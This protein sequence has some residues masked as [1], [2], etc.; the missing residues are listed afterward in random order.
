MIQIEQAYF[1]ERNNQ[2][3]LLCSSLNN[4]ELHRQLIPLTDRPA[5]LN[6]VKPY[7]SGY[8]FKEY[9]VFV[10]T[11]PDFSAQR[12]GLVFSHSLILNKKDI[13]FINNLS[14]IFDLFIS[15]PLKETQTIESLF[16]EIGYFSKP[17]DS[18]QPKALSTVIKLMLDSDK[19]VVW[20]GYEY[21]RSI[22]EHLWLK[23]LPSM[24]SNFKFRLSDNPNDIIDRNYSIVYIPDQNLSKWTN[25]NVVSSN[26]DTPLT[27]PAELFLQ[28]K[29]DVDFNYFIEKF[30]IELKFPYELNRI[31]DCYILYKESQFKKDSLLYNRLVRKIGAI[32][33]SP[34]SVIDLKQEVLQSFTKA[35]L[36]SDCDTIAS[37]RSINFTPYQNGVDDVIIVLAKWCKINFVRKTTQSIKDLADLILIFFHQE[38]P[39][40]WQTTIE[41]GLISQF[42]ELTK[43]NVSLLFDI[44]FEK[45][46][47]VSLLAVYLE[48][49]EV[50]ENLIISS[51]NK[52]TSKNIISTLTN[53]SK[54]NKWILLHATCMSYL[55]SEQ[56]A[57]LKQC[58]FDKHFNTDLGL[59]KLIELFGEE[60][61]INIA[62]EQKEEELHI[63]A[64]KLCSKQ[65]FYL[66]N[67]AIDNL[68]WQKVWYQSLLITKNIES[69][70]LDPLTLVYSFLDLIVRDQPYFSE[71]LV[72]ISKSKFGNVL[73]FTQRH[74]LW[75]KLENPICI[76]FLEKTG[77]QYVIEIFSI[78]FGKL[79]KEL[80]NFLYLPSTQNYIFNA[81]SL[82][83]SNRL[84]YLLGIGK[85]DENKLIDY[86]D[87]KRALINN[88]DAEY[89][90]KLIFEN[91]WER[92]ADLV[93]ELHWNNNSLS[94]ALN[95][96]RSQLSWYKKIFTSNNSFGMNKTD[97]K[98]SAFNAKPK[99]FISYNHKD[100]D[101]ALKI[102]K[103][104]MSEKFEVIIDIDAM[105]TGQKIEEFIKR[106]I[107][108]SGVT[109][110]IVSENSLQSAWVAMET[111]Y[112][113]IE[114]DIRGRYFMPCK[115][116]D[117]IFDRKFPDQAMDKIDSI[118]EEI[119]S[120][121]IERVKKNRGIE[122]LTDERTRY[123]KLKSEL[124]TII[125][126]LKSALCSDLSDSNFDK[127]IKKVIKDLKN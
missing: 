88:I 76:T 92:A 41:S 21:F 66:K 109:L 70:V 26:S 58:A 118:L 33:P 98:G 30:G 99:I 77:H 90:G 127:G 45:E 37:I 120:L 83:V 1:G 20:F 61:F 52:D 110:S 13:P 38:N 79:E 18:P 119:N 28:N 106:C 115:I 59:L 125:G 80:K 111:I 81:E 123:N 25:Y 50:N 5:G 62:I 51:L 126:N 49:S 93:F 113:T 114:Q 69:G 12:Q 75:S 46:E 22:I 7:I 47:L 108:E 82:P 94:T 56:D 102:Q 107:R 10:Y 67:I 97:L 24:R 43:E 71:L 8:F 63:I 112:S 91:N 9:Y 68:N 48:K 19:T 122:D 103:A 35:I 85:L 39:E 23:L 34:D 29:G 117:R 55:F 17:L 27:T 31:S 54:Q 64:G 124:P 2:H 96:C 42:K 89:I 4:E 11:V 44:W 86:I 121:L 100:Q 104:L 101:Y 95:Y 116:D 16:F 3:Q 74:L 15:N 60:K 14:V 57:I 73:H 87:K 40:W 53:V 65:S 78:E 6:L 105:K 36:S 32:A 84:H 72:L